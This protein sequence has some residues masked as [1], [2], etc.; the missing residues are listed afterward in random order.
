MNTTVPNHQVSLLITEKLLFFILMFSPIIHDIANID[1]EDHKK[2]YYPNLCQDIDNFLKEIFKSSEVNDLEKSNLNLLSIEVLKLMIEWF[3]QDWKTGD[4]SRT[5]EQIPQIICSIYNLFLSY[6]I[7]LW[8]DKDT[9]MSGDDLLE[10]MNN[11]Y[12]RR[13]SCR[14]VQF[15]GNRTYNSLM[16]L[17]DTAI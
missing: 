15:N 3:Y 14:N 8:I 6:K 17:T 5:K 2:W 13:H 16:Q 4:I 12:E 11:K 7:L 1:K 10:S 9:R